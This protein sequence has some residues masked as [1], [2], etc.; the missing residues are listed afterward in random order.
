MIYGFYVLGV[1]GTSVIL[2]L[3]SFGYVCTLGTSIYV[4]NRKLDIHFI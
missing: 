2:G 3:W 1:G 4:L